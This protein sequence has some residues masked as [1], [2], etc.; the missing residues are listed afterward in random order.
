GVAHRTDDVGGR[1]TG[2]RASAAESARHHRAEG[3]GPA[4]VA[5]A[6]A[7]RANEGC[8]SPGPKRPTGPATG[9]AHHT[10]GIS[11]QGDPSA[12]A[13]QAPGALSGASRHRVAGARR[14]PEPAAH[15]PAIYRS[16]NA[17]YRHV[18][19]LLERQP[20]RGYLPSDRGLHRRPRPQG[21]LQGLRRD[22]SADVSRRP[23]GHRALRAWRE[24]PGR[25]RP[26]TVE[27]AAVGDS[28]SA[29][30]RSLRGRPRWAPKPRC[31]GS[32]GSSELTVADRH[33]GNG[34]RYRSRR[35]RGEELGLRIHRRIAA[36]ADALVAAVGLE[37][38]RLRVVPETPVEIAQDALG[39]ALAADR[40]GDLHA[41]EEVALH[42]VGARAEHVRLA[43]VLEVEHPRVLEEAPDDRAHR[44]VLRYARQARA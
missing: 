12:G 8:R 11:R 24:G 39:V 2:R 35:V 25:R 1:I 37:L 14:A 13:A 43:A 5:L 4:P 10:P 28:V 17:G 20:R 40:E 38:P 6:R 27:L 33:L 16:P 7:A 15:A 21:G 32:A 41:A 29:G 18:P 44:D 42:P 36:A 31:R 9:R 3:Q 26:R 19:R 30:G 22:E 34:G 23:G